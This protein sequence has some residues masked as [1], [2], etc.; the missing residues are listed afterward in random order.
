MPRLGFILIRRWKAH[1]IWDRPCDRRSKRAH[2]VNCTGHL[3]AGLCS[4][5]ATADAPMRLTSSQNTK[6]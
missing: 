4:M 3:C 5:L 1:F 6:R 2:T